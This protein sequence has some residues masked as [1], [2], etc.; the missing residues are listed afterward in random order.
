MCVSLR[1][2]AECREASPNLDPEHDGIDY[3]NS[4]QHVPVFSSVAIAKA[5]QLGNERIKERAPNS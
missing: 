4:P 3:K 2:G 1:Q 5:D